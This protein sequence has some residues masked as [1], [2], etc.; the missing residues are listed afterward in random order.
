MG[1]PVGTHILIK[2]LE[3]DSLSDTVITDH[4]RLD[5]NKGEILALGSGEIE[6]QERITF[7]VEVGDIV[8]YTG[9]HGEIKLENEKLGLIKHNQIA[10]AK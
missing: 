7:D 4:V 9:K 2:P 6:G 5:Y 1:R 3:N 10:Y 8:Y